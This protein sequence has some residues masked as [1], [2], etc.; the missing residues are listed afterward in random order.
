VIVGRFDWYQS[1]VDAPVCDVRAL[2]SSL[3]DGARWEAMKSG[4]HGYASGAKLVASDGVLVQLLWGGMH[5]L[6]HV[7]GTGDMAQPVADLLRA[8]Y[9]GNHTVSRAD[10]C[11]DY[12]QPG[13]Y[14]QL[15]GIALGVASSRA[16]KVGTAGD[17]KL[18]MKGRTLY[19]GS[20][21]STTI[22]RLYDKAEELRCKF[23]NNPAKLLAI[24]DELARLEVQ[25]RPKT[26]QAKHQAASLHPQEFWGAAAWTRDLHERVEGVRML[27]FH[28]DRPWRQSDDERAYD[29]MLSMFGPMLMRKVLEHG[30]WDCLGL[31]IGFDLAERQV[32]KRKH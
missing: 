7:V 20:T 17:H 22:V 25:V 1:T 2:L 28:A 21:S 4:R 23:H 9:A 8:A 6:P 14:D 27:P 30:A 16:V 13:A 12:A 18:T 15:E 10:V 3:E 24:P 32:L 19:L 31:Q 26:P 5:A 11:H 29:A